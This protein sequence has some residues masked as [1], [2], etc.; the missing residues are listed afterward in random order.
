MLIEPTALP[1]AVT[2]A[3]APAF[4]LAAMASWV[5]AMAN[6]LA[7]ITDR[8][9]YLLELERSGSIEQQGLA[10]LINLKALAATIEYSMIW[11]ISGAIFI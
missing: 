1:D 11:M 2:E 5:A 10:D 7:R 6:R 3:M 8:V 4:V 9:R